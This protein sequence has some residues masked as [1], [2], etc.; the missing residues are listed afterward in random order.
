MRASERERGG[1]KEEE[2]EEAAEE[3]SVSSINMLE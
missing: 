3:A 1:V 2:E